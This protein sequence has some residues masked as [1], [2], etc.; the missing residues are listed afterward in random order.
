MF[1]TTPYSVYSQHF[2]RR[3]CL[4]LL[5]YQPS[6]CVLQEEEAAAADADAAGSGS[7]HQHLSFQ[8]TDLFAMQ[9]EE[10]QQQVQVLQAVGYNSLE[11]FAGKEGGPPGA[12]T[13][14]LRAALSLPP[15]RPG[16]DVPA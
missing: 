12:V 1:T 4:C 7:S 14:A 10:L 11:G 16:R 6:G 9:V 8:Q 15:G 13:Q 3:W 2:I 5:K